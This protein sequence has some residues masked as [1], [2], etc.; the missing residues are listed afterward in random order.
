MDNIWENVKILKQAYIGL[1]GAAWRHG[2]QEKCGHNY[3]TYF[4]LQ[5]LVEMVWENVIIW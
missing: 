4:G 2:M 1:L 3:V 5:R